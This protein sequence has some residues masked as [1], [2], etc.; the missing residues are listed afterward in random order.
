MAG[1]EEWT[2]WWVVIQAFRVETW[3]GMVVGDLRVWAMRG[4]GRERGSGR[5][6]GFGRKEE[7]DVERHETGVK[8]MGI[9]QDPPKKTRCETKPQSQTPL[10]RLRLLR[11]RRAGFQHVSQKCIMFLHLL[12][13]AARDVWQMPNSACFSSWSGGRRRL[14]RVSSEGK[15]GSS[16]PLVLSGS[17]ASLPFANDILAVFFLF[18]RRW[19]E[20]EL[21]SLYDC[22]S[23]LF[24]WIV[25]LLIERT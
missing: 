22:F 21:V 3:Y 23:T 12:G 24:F 17:V 7:E 13:H 9:V 10:Q 14:E 8:D 4:F 25:Y 19:Y 16:F 20:Y 1:S 5:A 11:Q 2:R 18:T 6:R 15:M